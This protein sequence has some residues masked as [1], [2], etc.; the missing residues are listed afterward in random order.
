MP[1]QYE[2]CLES[3]RIRLLEDMDGAISSRRDSLSNDDIFNLRIYI[4]F[5]SPDGIPT[6][7]LFHGW[8]NWTNFL[9]NQVLATSGGKQPPDWSDQ[10]LCRYEK[11]IQFG[12]ADLE[13]KVFKGFKILLG[14]YEG[15]EPGS[16]PGDDE[17]F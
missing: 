5:V 17:P 12:V 3:E 15:A 6:H 13:G 1:A 14:E 8:S 7:K 2:L 4:R 16:T 10:G 9:L 11:F